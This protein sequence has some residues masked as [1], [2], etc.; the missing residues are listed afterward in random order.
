LAFAVR[1]N[2]M[3]EAYIVRGYVECL[4][5]YMSRKKSYIGFLTQNLVEYLVLAI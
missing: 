4:I 5:V 2:S 3:V 1:M